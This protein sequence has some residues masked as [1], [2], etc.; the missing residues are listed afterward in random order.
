MIKPRSAKTAKLY[1]EHRVPLVKRLLA[2]RTACERCG[3][4]KSVDIHEVKSRAR[5]GSILDESNLRAVCRKC[6][7]WITCNPQ[8]AHDTGW[9]KWSWE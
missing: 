6:H 7:N 5:G 3:I 2:E 9:L 8:E 4:A 1:K